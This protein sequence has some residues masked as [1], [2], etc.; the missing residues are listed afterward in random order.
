[1]QKTLFAQ[2]LSKALNGM[3]DSKEIESLIEVP[4]HENHGDFAFPCFTL[5]KSLRKSPQ[6]IAQEL[7][8][9]IQDNSFEKAEAA[10]PYVNVFLNKQKFSHDT[11]TAILAAGKEYGSSGIGDGDTITIDLS[12]PN[13]AK[14][15][16]MGHLRSTVI[17]NALANIAEKLGYQTVRINHLGDWGTQFGKLIVAYQKWGSEEKVRENAIE[18]LLSLYVRFHEEAETNKNLEDEARAWFKKLEDGDTEAQKLWKWFRDESLEEFK[19]IYELLGVRFDSFNGEAFY[20]DKLEGV[21]QLLEKKSLLTESDGASVVDLSQW[22]LPPCLITK[23][24]GASLYATRDLAAALYRQK[25]YWFKKAWYVVGQEQSLHFK[26]L[27]LVL[28]KMGYAWAD[29]M[30]HIPFGLILKDGKKMSTRKGKVVLLEDVLNEMIALAKKNIED[31]NPGLENKEAVAKMV[32]VGALIYNDLK[33]ERMN[34]FDFSMEE[35]LKF[36]G[37]TG[38]YVQYTHARARSLLKKSGL[39]VFGDFVGLDDPYSWTVIKLLNE[40]PEAIERSFNATEPSQL[41]KYLMHLS[42]AFNKFYAHVKVLEENEERTARLALVKS[43][44]MI[45]EEGLNLLGIQAPEEM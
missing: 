8:V 43:V 25:E 24:D 13:I 15:F 22:E 7:A 42:Q 33:N 45:L 1:M 2:T 39:E 31:K 20:N 16:S 23:S 34:N 27:F 41:A 26:Q 10:G 35:M 11:L 6:L 44:A 30:K 38:P 18:E 5:A 19:R 29:E 28:K 4:K 37:E 21:K 17:G 32:G 14:P 40:F 36:E 3:L 9:Q 12:S